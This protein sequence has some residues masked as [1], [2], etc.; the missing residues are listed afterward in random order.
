MYNALDDR[1]TAGV[2]DVGSTHSRG[3]C[4]STDR[5]STTPEE[6]AGERSEESFGRLELMK[7]RSAATRFHRAPNR[8]G[9]G[10]PPRSGPGSDERRRR[11]RGPAG[12]ARLLA[13]APGA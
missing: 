3:D 11:R 7:R 1:D 5:D 10:F 8:P 12:P 13:R 2:F 6:G 4:D 9:P